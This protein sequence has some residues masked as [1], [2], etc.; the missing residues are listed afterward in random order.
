MDE[1]VSALNVWVQAAVTDLLMDIQRENKATL[2]II[3]DDLS[4]VRYPSDQVLVM[5]LGHAVE[6]GSTDQVFQ[7]PYPPYPEA[8]LSAVPVADTK[9]IRKWWG[10]M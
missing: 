5:Y 4:I 8:L 1:P 10:P 2:L 3:S 6:M 9:V 7:S